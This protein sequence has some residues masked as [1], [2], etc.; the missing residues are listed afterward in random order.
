MSAGL[1]VKLLMLMNDADAKVA[2][3]DDADA[4]DT[5]DANDAIADA[6][7]D[8]KPGLL[9]S[10]GLALAVKLLMLRKIGS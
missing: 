4:D 2:D 10:V 9:L 7:D 5:I 8:S 1:A 6:D 3:T